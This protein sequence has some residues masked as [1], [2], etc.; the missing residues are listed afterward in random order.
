MKLASQ[1]KKYLQATIDDITE[2]TKKY[3]SM[4]SGSDV[5]ALLQAELKNY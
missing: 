4:K 5:K 3:P 1:I 2:A